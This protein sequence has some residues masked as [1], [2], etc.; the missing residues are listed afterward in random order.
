[1]LITSV[2]MITGDYPATALAVA[3]EAG[4]AAQVGI[5]TGGEIAEMGSAA[6][7]GHIRVYG[8]DVRDALIVSR[9]L[10]DSQFAVVDV[11]EPDPQSSNSG[12][13]GR[14]RGSPRSTDSLSSIGISRS[15]STCSFSIRPGASSACSRG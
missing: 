3:H 9:A 12:G 7:R 14:S 5:L 10:R 13:S 11:A 1:M 4:V 2:A 15:M 8:L 6:L